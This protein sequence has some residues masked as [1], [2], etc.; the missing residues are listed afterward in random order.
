MKRA[1]I[2]FILTDIEGTTTSVSYVFDV[3]FPYFRKHLSD[4]MNHKDLPEVQKAF[5]QVNELLAKEGNA[6]PLSDEEMLAVLEKW[7]LEDRKVTPLKTIQGVIWKQGYEAGE[8]IGH[9][10][11][12][13]PEN[14]KNWHDK[15]ELG[16]FSSGSVEAQQLIF[17]FSEAGDLSQYVDYFFDT[18][19]G[20]KRDWETYQKIANRT[21]LAPSHILFLSDVVAELE[22]A[23]KTGMLTIQLVR[24]GTEAAWETT[25]IDFNEVEKL[26]Y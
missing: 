5:E 23:Q 4:V 14:L 24:P 17:G 6:L 7:S 19:T 2:R 3:L 13:V 11:D 20:Q 12:D 1:D 26:I 22:A 18:N 8:L 9:V 15:Y 25:A 21:H 10:Y 16:I